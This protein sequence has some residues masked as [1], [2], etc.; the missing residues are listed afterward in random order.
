MQL[1]FEFE[2][3]RRKAFV[4]WPKTKGNIVVHLTDSELEAAFPTDLYY[5]IER[6]NKVTF[7]IEDSRDKRLTELQNILARRLQELV[8]R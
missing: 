2:D 5:E 4:E 1:Y 8:N 7:T 6:G 3:K